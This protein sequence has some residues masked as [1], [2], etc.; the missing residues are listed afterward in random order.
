M[1]T[2]LMP[3]GFEKAPQKKDHLKL[4]AGLLALVLFIWLASLGANFWLKN[5]SQDT[6]TQI[7]NINEQIEASLGSQ[8]ATLVRKL[9]EVSRLLN[10]RVYWSDFLTRL[11]KN[12]LSSTIFNSFSGK[13]AEE[14]SVSLQGS[15]D[16]YTSL[17]QQ[18]LVF[19]DVFKSVD[20]SLT[21]GE[22]ADQEGDS[23]EGGRQTDGQ[24]E[25]EGDQQEDV[26]KIQASLELT[27]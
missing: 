10:K 17:A 6:E 19:K 8:T 13:A 21:G 3:E 24:Q 15:F 12:T 2:N 16:N 9:E 5:K 1:P 20:F 23:E 27:F 26:S 18:V 22:D 25:G 11:E 14:S 7:N 4:T